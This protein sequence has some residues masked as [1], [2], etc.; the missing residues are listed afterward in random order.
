MENSYI[1]VDTYCMLVYVDMHLLAHEQNVSRKVYKKLVT[2]AA[3]REGTGRL[4][5][6]GERKAYILFTFLHLLNI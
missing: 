4:R 6:R 1:N 3:T 2:L 5:P